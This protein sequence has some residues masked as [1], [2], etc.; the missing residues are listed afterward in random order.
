MGFVRKFCVVEGHRSFFYP[1]MAEGRTGHL[2]LKFLGFI[3]LI[4]SCQG[5]FSFIVHYIK[6]FEGIFNIVN[7]LPKK[8]KAIIVAR[9]VEEILSLFEIC[10]ASSALFYLV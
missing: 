5:L 9:F 6:E 10:R 3:T 4:N 1:D 2:S 8:N 7:T